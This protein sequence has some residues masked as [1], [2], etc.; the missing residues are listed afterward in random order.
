MSSRLLSIFTICSVRGGSMLSAVTR[1]QQRP[2][3]EPAIL[4]RP[5]CVDYVFPAGAPCSVLL[6]CLEVWMTACLYV[7]SLWYTGS[8]S[9]CIPPLVPMW[10]GSRGLFHKGGL[11]TLLTNRLQME[12][13][14]CFTND[15]CSQIENAVASPTGVY[16]QHG[17]HV[18]CL[19]WLSGGREEGSCTHEERSVTSIWNMHYSDAELYLNANYFE[20][21]IQ[22]H[23]TI[24]FTEIQQIPS[25]N[26]HH[27]QAVT[28][29]WWQEKTPFNR[30]NPP[31]EISS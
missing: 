28:W 26:Y 9:G 1:Q 10:A 25:R 27:H 11:W 31:A 13:S 19:F 4:L 21:S 2:Q 20:D 17:S 29:W 30:Q 8:C 3:F 15:C 22:D 5:F 7:S 12:A 6:N 18:C 16:M 14:H 24:I 23:D